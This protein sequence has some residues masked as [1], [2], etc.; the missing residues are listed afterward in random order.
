MLPGLE[1][2]TVSYPQDWVDKYKVN[3]KSVFNSA[4]KKGDAI[5]IYAINARGE[6]TQANV[7]ATYDGTKWSLPGGEKLRN[8]TS[9]HYFAYFPYV[10][11]DDQKI[12]SMPKVGTKVSSDDLSSEHAFFKGLEDNWEVKDQ[13]TLEKLNA[14]D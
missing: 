13:S 12:A 3:G 14:A 5:G 7:K 8:N 11:D 9:I 2:T 10:T 1:I 6:V 4:Y